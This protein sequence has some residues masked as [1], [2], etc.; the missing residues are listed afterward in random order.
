MKKA[1]SLFLSLALLLSGAAFASAEETSSITWEEYGSVA[2][3]V[4]GEDARFVSIPEVNAKVWI[5]NYLEPVTLTDEDR[6]NDIIAN[7]LA[8]D[9]SEMV[10]ISYSPAAGLTLEA[11][12]KAL[13]DSGVHPDLVE[14][15]GIP[16][17]QYYSGEGDSLIANYITTDNY[18]L[19]F[20]FYPFSNELSSFLFTVILSSVQP[21]TGES[22][23]EEASTPVNPVSGLISK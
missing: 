15:N 5:P 20:I 12:K 23:S 6:A 14:I 22:A 16:V 2:G 13:E 18:L 10:M 11:F 3:E 4:F 8:S 7:Y 17:L 9:E 1:L 21:D 19:Q